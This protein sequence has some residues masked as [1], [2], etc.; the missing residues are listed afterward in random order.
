MLITMGNV[1]TR[2]A[3]LAEYT[4]SHKV[5]SD[6]WQAYNRSQDHDT[7]PSWANCYKA[8]SRHAGCQKSAM[9]NHMRNA[10]APYVRLKTAV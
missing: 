5:D 3:N 4:D 6:A 7:L 9:R 10:M 8:L 2:N 1:L